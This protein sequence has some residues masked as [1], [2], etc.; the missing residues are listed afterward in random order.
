MPN[1][2]L[3]PS[4]SGYSI[5]D[6]RAWETVVFQV[7]KPVLDKELIL[8]SD[9]ASGAT[10]DTLTRLMPSGWISEDF[11]GSSSA[12]YNTTTTLNTLD[13]AGCLAHV[14]GWL[15]RVERTATSTAANRVDLGAAPTGLGANRTDLVILEVWR[16]LISAATSTAGKSALGRIWLNGNVKIA[17]ADDATLNL[18][19]D[20][21]DTNVATETTKR[22]QIQYRLRVI[23]GVDVFTY[24]YGMGDPLVVATTVPASAAAPDGVAYSGP[25][26][27]YSSMSTN[28]DPGLWRAGD[29]NPSNALGTVD[30]YI[31]A[32]PLCAVFRRNSTAFSRLTNNNG[33]AAYPGT[34]DRPDGL[35][36]NII[37]PVDVLDLRCGVSPTGWTPQEVLSKNLNFLLDN[38]LRQE[39][40][41]T[42]VGGG[43]RGTT[44]LQTN[45]IGGA[46]TSAGPVIGQFDS[47]RRRFSDRATYETVVVAIPPPSGGWATGVAAID[48][49]NF[50]PVPYTA[51]SWPANAPATAMIID[52]LELHWAA[53]F[54]SSSTFK[55]VDALPYVNRISGGLG[56]T[57]KSLITITFASLSSL[58]L[59]NE[60][61]FVTLT[62]AYPRDGGLS[63]TPV[64][65]Y[66]NSSFDL[67]TGQL[68][69]STPVS[70]G[71][72]SAQTIDPVH[73]EVQIEYTTSEQ[74]YK[75]AA[76]G[77]PLGPH[78][79]VYQLPE[80]ASSITSIAPISGTFTLDPSGRFFT[81]GS[82]PSGALTIKYAA[83]RPVPLASN[84]KMAVYFRSAASAAVSST[85]AG[86]SLTVVPRLV[87]EK[88]LTMTSGSGSQGEGYPFPQAYVQTGGVNPGSVFASEY[89]GESSMAASPSLSVTDFSAQTGM[90]MLPTYVPMVANPEALT[91]TRSPGD[92]DVES[93]TYYSGASSTGYLPNAYAASFSSAGRHKNILPVLAELP[94]DTAFGLKGQIVVVLL[95]RY[96]HIDAINGVFFDP[97]SA[98]TT[99]ASVFRVKGL[100]LNKRV[101]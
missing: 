63:H 26:A 77:P 27:L 99:C 82:P 88:L 75:C 32:V 10:Q 78:G 53:P 49:Y 66:G 28:G 86:L 52:V 24:P 54:G 71:A 30:G 95:V 29:G 15:V 45:E 84:A 9:L 58:G 16:R 44:V 38:A 42:V 34:S 11:L 37:T 92:V 93:R 79:T 13:F 7:G 33:A 61:L 64:A 60:H 1:K 4:S 55:Y 94:Q 6:G 18:V 89:N 96:A 48:P 35:F 57:T 40:T 12:I 5:P 73:R 14:N 31:Y 67:T 76:S 69:A 3:G 74:T 8:S 25:N 80:R 43:N 22:V 85:L 81:L 20:I 56:T 19:D 23:K 72:F 46:P 2:N 39:P 68:S 91:L 98:N 21:K 87:S 62:L 36:H 41:F 65:T 51:F 50:T 97:T 101:S 17:S 100:L 83:A 47:V 90:L 70:F 59:T